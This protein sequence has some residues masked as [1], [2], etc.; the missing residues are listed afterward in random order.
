MR[1]RRATSLLAALF[2][3]V[4]LCTLGSGCSSRQV[5]LRRPFWQ[6]AADLPMLHVPGLAPPSQTGE[7][8]AE[9]VEGVVR[10]HARSP[11]GGADHLL[12]LARLD[13]SRWL[14]HYRLGGGLQ[15][16]VARG[17]TVH[18]VVLQRQRAADL[19]VDRGLLLYRWRM[20]AGQTREQLAAAIDTRDILARDRLPAPLATIQTTDIAVYHDAGPYGDDCDELRSHQ[21][22]RVR[23]GDL[24][25]EVRGRS[26]AGLIAPG[27]QA[28]LDDG[29]DR[30]LV[31]FLD[32][33]TTPQ[34]TCRT[35]PAPNWAW[36]AIR[37]ARL[38]DPPGTPIRRVLPAPRPFPGATPAP[39]DPQAP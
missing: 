18:I 7:I 35:T 27:G 5:V 11:L 20:V 33:R 13:G 32:N 17:D 23:P 14:L 24:P 22:F 10:A 28:T 21:F 6:T 4:V 39:V 15:L 12:E 25:A 38:V 19:Q 37:K 8:V 30:F 3:T 9:N 34:T 16:P 36:S 2:A 31:L 29:S 26:K 1:S